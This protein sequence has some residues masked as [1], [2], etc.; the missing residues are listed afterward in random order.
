MFCEKFQETYIRLK[1]KDIYWLWL[2]EDKVR[3]S[4]G[5]GK[6]KVGRRP[7]LKGTE[8]RQLGQTDLKWRTSKCV[9]RHLAIRSRR[10]FGSS[11]QSAMAGFQSGEDDYSKETSVFVVR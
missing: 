5:I 8:A 3:D 2:S 6:Q 11:N 7:R 9:S 4:S 1:R 10:S